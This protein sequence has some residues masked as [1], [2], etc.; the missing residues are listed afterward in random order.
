[1]ATAVTALDELERLNLTGVTP[2]GEPV[3]ALM[4]SQRLGIS[5]YDAAYLATAE[6]RQ[7]MLVTYDK[8]LL[9]AAEGKLD[10][11]V[12]IDRLCSAGF[13]EA[14]CTGI[15]GLLRVRE[16]PPWPR[17]RPCVRS[18]ARSSACGKSARRPAHAAGTSGHGTG[19]SASPGSRF[20]L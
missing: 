9:E 1:M 5:V 14:G 19:A 8:R 13:G 4:Y 7:A 11:V 20:W 12:K 3:S 16:Q 17:S 15:A 2:A 10:W 6:A 18:D